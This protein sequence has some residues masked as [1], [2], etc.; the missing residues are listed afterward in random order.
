MV[1]FEK[2]ESVNHGV[3]DQN[4]VIALLSKDS[5]NS[6]LRIISENPERALLQLLSKVDLIEAAGGIVRDPV[7]NR[8]LV[9]ERFGQWDF[10]K[11]KID[12]G[13]TPMVA[14]IREV[15][16]EC[17]ID[18]L[19]ITS[20]IGQT[21]HGYMLQNHPCI[22]RTYWFS[23]DCNGNKQTSAQVEEG[24]TQAVWVDKSQIDSLLEK[25]YPSIKELW[26]QTAAT[27]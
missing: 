11:G 20:D 10:P 9:I 6:V 4:D 13:E 8:F 25:S 12:S 7:T 24:I 15:E 1:V 23:M 2:G 22:K 3:L 17:G 27:I 19:T 18:G 14:S 21:Y 16:E 5:P 26:K